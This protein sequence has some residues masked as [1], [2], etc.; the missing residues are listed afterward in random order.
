[1]TILREPE[2]EQRAPSP[3]P[4]GRLVVGLTIVGAGLLWLMERLDVVDF[5]AGLVLPVLVTMVGLGL[6]ASWRDQTHGGLIALGVILSV[7]TMVSAMAFPVA[8]VG[9]RAFRPLTQADL[10]DEYELTAG[11]L[12]LD[13]SALEV[14]DT[15]RVNAS[16]GFGRI[17][18]LVPD[19]VRVVAEG[20]TLMGQMQML[21]TSDEGVDLDR[22]IE[23]GA[24]SAQ[25][26]LDLSV[27]AGEIH[28]TE[29]DR[30]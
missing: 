14:S 15:A 12:S 20:H 6:L 21:G 8:A 16:V 24:G 9:D 2:V 26:I 5:D 23:T 29:V 7:V 18:V 17:D 22:R 27:V 1:M 13:L 25:L 4:T 19:G 3:R 30:G 28:V 10:L 11:N